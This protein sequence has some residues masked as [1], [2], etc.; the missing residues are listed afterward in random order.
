MIYAQ[1][2][3]KKLN[4]FKKIITESDENAFITV[5]ESKEILNG[6]FGK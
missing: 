6:Y 5:N 3:N 2:D 1:I 4:E